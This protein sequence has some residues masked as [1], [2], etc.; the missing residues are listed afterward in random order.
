MNSL[1]SILRELGLV[2]S[3]YAAFKEETY[4]GF[5][6]LYSEEEF[7]VLINPSEREKIDNEK[8]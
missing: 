1:V 4:D 7:K 8:P 2:S 3:V 5:E 6:I